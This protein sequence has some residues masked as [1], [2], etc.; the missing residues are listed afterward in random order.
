MSGVTQGNSRTCGRHPE[1]R[2][3]RYTVNVTCV[4]GTEETGNS[5]QVP[6]VYGLSEPTLSVSNSPLQ[7]LSHICRDRRGSV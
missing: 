3:S 7:T 4:W 1:S 6:E 5:D 2:T